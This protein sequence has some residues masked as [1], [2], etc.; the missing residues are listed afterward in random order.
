MLFGV[1]EAD[2]LFQ[3]QNEI[4]IVSSTSSQ[5]NLDDDVLT[6]HMRVDETC[7]LLDTHGFGSSCIRIR[8]NDGGNSPMISTARKKAR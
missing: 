5:Q 3:I 4:L 2:L 1:E 7:K 6:M 8:C